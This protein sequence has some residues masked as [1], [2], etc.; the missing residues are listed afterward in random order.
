MAFDLAARYY[1]IDK[2]LDPEDVNTNKPDKKSILMYVMCLYHAIDSIREQQ[3]SLACR[4]D[5]LH[6]LAQ[7]QEHQSDRRTSTD[8]E[9]TMLDEAS[10]SASSKTIEEEFDEIYH[11]GNLTDLDE[12]SLAKSI[13][14]LSKFAMPTNIKRSSTFTITTNDAGFAALERNEMASAE[15]TSGISAE[16]AAVS[17]IQFFM[18]SRSRPVSTATNAS[19]E[20]GGYQNAIEMVLSLLLEAEEVL[21]KD[22]P[23]ILDVT[24]ARQQ[25][26]DHED[27]MVKLSEYQEYVGAA[28][29]EGARLLTEPAANTG[30]NSDDQTEIKKQMVLLNER[31]E[32]L[33]MRA[34]TVQS[35]VHGKLAEVQLQKIE[36]LRILLTETEDKISRMAEIDPRPDAMRVQFDEHK[37]LEASLNEQKTLVDELG[38]LVVIVNDDSFNELEDKLAALG[39]RWSHVVKWTKNRFERLQCTNWKWRMLNE[40]FV[41]VRKWMDAREKDLKAMEQRP[42]TAIGDVMDRMNN[43]RYCAA[44]L[45]VLCEHLTQLQ[46]IGQ[47]LQPAG[48]AFLAKLE[49]L[50]D[51]CEALTEIVEVQQQ[52]IQSM[53]FN[54]NF[55]AGSSDGVGTPSGWTDFQMKIK[56]T[57]RKSNV[58]LLAKDDEL[59]VDLSG[60]E[61]ASPQSNKKRR[62]QK[63][64]DQRLLEHHITEMT[65]FVEESE[66]Q[67]RDLGEKRSLKAEHAALVALEATIKQRIVA[68][69][70]VK[71][72]LDR[73]HTVE[74]DAAELASESEAITGLGTKYDEL[75]IRVEH[76]LAVNKA[77]TVKEKFYRNLTG[78]KLILADCQD[79]YKQ[80]ANAA[81]STA[82]ELKNRLTYM[83]SLNG[84]I[85]EAKAFGESSEADG[86]NEWKHDFQQFHQSW[87]DIKSAIVQLIDTDFGAKPANETAGVLDTALR[88]LQDMADATAVVVST[89]DKMNGRLQQL[90]VAMTKCGDVRELLLAAADASANAALLEHWQKIANDLNDRIIKQTTAMENSNHF[91]GELENVMAFLARTEDQLNADVFIFGETN[92]LHIQHKDYEAHGMDMKKAEIDIISVKNFSEI[93]LKASTDADYTSALHSQI[94]QLNDRLGHVK[95]LYSGKLGELKEISRQTE[96]MVKQLKETDSWLT[97]L[98]ASIPKTQNADIANA[99]ELFQLKS[100]F[101]AWKEKC[102]QK[103]IEF[104]QLNEMGS[105]R[106]MQID[107]QLSRPTCHRK[108]SSLAKQ[109]T[110]LNARW[111]DVTVLVY[112]RAALLEHISG[113][114]GE[115]KTMI[116]SETGYLDKM[117]KCLRKSPENAADAE[118]IYEELD[119]SLSLSNIFR[120]RKHTKRHNSL[121]TRIES[122]CSSKFVLVPAIGVEMAHRVDQIYCI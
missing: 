87:S 101:Q 100:K 75:N 49:M 82:D 57:A 104:R 14:D 10:S 24:A 98:E 71:Q 92:D 117:E 81:A 50:Q 29:E 89:Q 120:Y 64:E 43:L 52:R 19:T 28:L 88:G 33:R 96:H 6:T 93:I 46:E 13:E 25:F 38:N 109:F 21:S 39:E 108:Y 95:E 63:S 106:L 2:L 85:D 80:Y 116:V 34:L 69:A 99:I 110:R 5:S 60:D 44:D 1:N 111:T 62:L 97:E 36:E 115:L 119:V 66:R 59:N 55:A 91:D 112:T 103:S 94:V 27:F 68:Y 15:A 35:H 4:A 12:I 73:C 48:R 77:N 84:E 30:L 61:D 58:S 72:L 3:M 113:Q 22:L 7:Q 56:Q 79:W 102:E 54:F 121:A 78:F 8:D 70:G 40:R 76:L 83:E 20:I 41:V 16:P 37:V 122:C 31:W 53:G 118:E 45:K 42:V 32:T 23:E 17:N 26:Q 107:E 114:L 65:L 90:M 105:E 18:E 86:M 47:E 74:G 51:R 9:I 11:A 67:L